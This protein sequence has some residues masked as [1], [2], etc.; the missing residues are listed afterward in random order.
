[1]QEE[2][3]HTLAVKFVR[4]FKTVRLDVGCD[5]WF[6]DCVLCVLCLDLEVTT[7]GRLKNEMLLK[8]VKKLSFLTLQSEFGI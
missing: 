3:S 1:M 8:E 2:Y 7:K 4:N 6:E 5:W